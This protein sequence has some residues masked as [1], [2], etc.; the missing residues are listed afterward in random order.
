MFCIPHLT[1]LRELLLKGLD[2]ALAPSQM[3]TSPFDNF[4][5]NIK[6]HS[7]YLKVICI[8]CQSILNKIS[9][10]EILVF[11][12]DPD[13]ICVSESWC[14]NL[15]INTVNIS[16]YTMA[17]FFVRRH[18]I[19]GGVLILIKDSISFKNLDNVSNM[20]E[21]MH[22]EFCGISFSLNGRNYCLLNVYRPPDGN[23]GVFIDRVSQLLMLYSK[24]FVNIILC[25]DV[26]IDYLVDSEEKTIFCD[27]VDSYGLICQNF[28]PTRVFTNKYGYTSV[29]KI[30]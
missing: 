9:N 5:S 15:N 22:S 12:E 21:E 27:L 2:F 25:G 11:K 30:D 17:S 13:I 16:N 28:D 8:N 14:N 29:S 4:D 23:I 18:H 3:I 10:I 7:N 20:S 6:I 24:Q 1:G 26:N 19:H